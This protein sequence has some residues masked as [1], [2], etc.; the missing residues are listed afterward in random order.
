MARKTTD[1][2]EQVWSYRPDVGYD[3]TT[4]LA[5]F[6]V[7]ALDGRIGRIAE[8]GRQAT[9]DY[10]VVATG[11]W[12][13]DRHVVLPA[14]AVA[15][16]DAARRTVLVDR[17]RQQI[18]DAPTADAALGHHDRGHLEELERYYGTFYASGKV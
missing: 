6:H 15:R 18:R 1:T 11:P 10:L 4:K 14:G 13:H 3:D 9:S 2:P 16:I 17:T 5:G 8:T 12:F 7:E